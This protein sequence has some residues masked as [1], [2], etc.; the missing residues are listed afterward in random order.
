MLLIITMTVYTNVGDYRTLRYPRDL[1]VFFET[2]IST[3]KVSD[4][5]K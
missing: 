5:L 4:N 1:L 3:L 2:Y